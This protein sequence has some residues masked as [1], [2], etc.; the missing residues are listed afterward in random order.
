MNTEISPPQIFSSSFT[1]VNGQTAFNPQPNF[2]GTSELLSITRTVLNFGA[3]G[4]AGVPSSAVLS[5]TLALPDYYVGMVSSSNTDNST[6]LLKWINKVT[7]S[8]YLT[9]GVIA[10]VTQPFTVNQYYTP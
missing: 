5:P 7:T 2:N 8:N 4:S 10:G 6:Y 9:P 3:G 1:C